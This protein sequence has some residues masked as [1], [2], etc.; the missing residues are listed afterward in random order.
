MYINVC[1]VVTTKSNSSQTYI[2]QDLL[3]MLHLHNIHTL[4]WH[5]STSA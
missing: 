2:S 4:M 3:R 1:D 5:P